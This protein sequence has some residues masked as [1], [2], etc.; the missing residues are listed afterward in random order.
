MNPDDGPAGGHTPGGADY[1]VVLAQLTVAT[2]TGSPM[3]FDAQGYS[4]TSKH[5]WQEHCIE[6]MVGGPHSGAGSHSASGIPMPAQ[7]A[8]APSTKT[9]GASA[10]TPTQCPT[11]ADGTC[12]EG[13][14]KTNCPA[15]TDTADC[16]GEDCLTVDTAMINAY[17][18]R[19]PASHPAQ[20]CTCVASTPWLWL[21]PG[22]TTFAHCS[23]CSG[24]G[25]SSSEPGS[26]PDHCSRACAAV[27][28]PWWERCSPA[29]EVQQADQQMSGGL[30]RFYDTCM[31]ETGGH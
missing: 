4:A 13:T 17:A 8:G 14:D 1:D 21:T 9:P 20:A 28:K 25:S 29:Q 6:V 5:D 3:L 30:S 16:L 7:D 2:G 18:A 27:Y 19:H 15:G 26:I 12:D 10:T 31:R 24:K 22:L 23:S 11:A